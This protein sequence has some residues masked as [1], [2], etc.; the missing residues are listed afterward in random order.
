MRFPK[1]QKVSFLSGTQIVTRNQPGCAHYYVHGLNGDEETEDMRRHLISDELAAWLNGE[2]APSW[3]LVLMRQS[4]TVV[5]LQDGR[6]ISA[7]GPYYDA[8]PPD[9]FWQEN[10]VDDPQR[11]HLI[12]CLCESVPPRERKKWTYLNSRMPT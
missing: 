4:D 3:M 2:L 12:D 11:K 1:W 5:V 9:L 6:E 7:T 10:V 8:R